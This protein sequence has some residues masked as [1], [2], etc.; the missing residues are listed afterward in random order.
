VRRWRTLAIALAVGLSAISTAR[1]QSARS[2]FAPAPDAPSYK[3]AVTTEAGEWLIC[4]QT[5]KGPQAQVMA[6]EMAELI[7]G[8][9]YKLAAYLYDRGRKQ[10]AEEEERV[11]DLRKQYDEMI[12]QMKGQGVEPVGR[13]RVKTIDIEDEF[14]VLVGKPNRNF[15]DMDAARDFLNDVRKLKPPP[16][17][18]CNKAFAGAEDTGTQKVRS[19]YAYMNPFP[20]AMV[21]H[22]PSIPFVKKQDDPEKADDFIK[23]INSGES[24]SVFK[25]KKPWTLVVKV[26]QGQVQLAPK[27]TSLMSK[28]SFG[29][30]EPELLN[31]G[32]QNAHVIA[33]V[34]RSMKPSY[35]AFVMHHRSYSVVTVGQYDSKDDPELLAAQRSLAGLQ[36]K[37]QSTGVV[38]C[39]LSAQPLPMKIPR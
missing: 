33:G 22:N 6:E 34:L 21:V 32:A 27:N 4:V 3:Y 23:E 10:R 11:K 7:R 31:A 39:T 38:H 16:E 15:K 35:E 36:L 2:P 25:A 17:M 18:F 28:F 20:I 29:K 5:F 9:E 19:G 1:A 13:F 14:A 12:K 30:K 26:Y 8:R 37:D 24:Y